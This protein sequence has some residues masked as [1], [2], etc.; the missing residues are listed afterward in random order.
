MSKYVVYTSSEETIVFSKKDH[1]RE[2]EDFF[3]EDGYRNIDDYEKINIEGPVS[4][5]TFTEM[6]IDIT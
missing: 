2:F 1:K 5:S 6:Q 4:I 3:G